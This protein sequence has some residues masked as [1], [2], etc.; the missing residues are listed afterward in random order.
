VLRLLTRIVSAVAIVVFVVLVAAA[1]AYYVFGMRIVLDGSGGLNVRFPASADEQARRIEAHRQAQRTA[2]ADVAPPAAIAPASPPPEGTAVPG[3]AGVL[4]ADPA[5]AD[6]P[7]YRGPAR[8]GIVPV[9]AILTDWPIDGLTPLWKQPIGGG[10]ASLAVARGRAF[11]IEQR[12]PREVAAAYD[13]RTGRELWTTA[14]DALFQEFMGGDG[15]RATPTWADAVVYVLGATGEL[16]ALSDA[17]G[18]TIW[19]VNILDDNQAANVQWGMAGSPLVVDDT[20]V[21]HPGGGNGRSVVAYDRRTG[22]RVWAAQDDRAG[23]AAPM[24]ATLAGVRQIVVFSASRLMGLTPD[25][26]RLLW[27][28]PWRTEYDINAAQPIV[29]SDTRLFVSSG[30]GS[31]AAVIEIAREGATF[32]V[33]EVWR[34]IRMKNRFNSSVLHDGYIYG[35][36]EGIFACIDAATGD[37]KWKGGRYGYGQVLLAA[38][39]LI[40]LTED[41]DLALLRATPDRHDERARVPAIAGKTWNVPAMS[42]P[43]LLVRN[44]AEMAAFD[45][46][47]R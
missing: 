43:V 35:L 15:P 47:V 26:G 22:A 17:T 29:V 23:Y 33:R 19:R 27:E 34:N 24:L 32:T 5:L 40:V 44:I 42:G 30:Y 1:V 7:A 4:A 41:G 13:V 21:V 10:Y 11:T 18:R 6:W 8:D 46:S 28:Y 39:H 9:R 12:G 45:L 37:L 2:T 31:G 36:D 14:W 20:V 3:G 38:G 25:G 16:R